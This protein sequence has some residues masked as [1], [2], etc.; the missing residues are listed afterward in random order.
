MEA[1]HQFESKRQASCQPLDLQERN[2]KRVELG[3]NNTSRLTESKA[4]ACE[5]AHVRVRGWRVRARVRASLLCACS[6]NSV[7]VSVCKCV[8]E[9]LRACVR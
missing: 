1:S 9:C 6:R 3:L 2:G 8:R 7:C 5:C 4:F